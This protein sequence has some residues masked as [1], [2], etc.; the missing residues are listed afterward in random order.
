MSISLEGFFL[1]LKT[2]SVLLDQKNRLAVR[3]VGQFFSVISMQTRWWRKD[4]KGGAGACLFGAA[5]C[6]QRGNIGYHVTSIPAIRSL[7]TGST[8]GS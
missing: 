7:K 6:K 3:V 4:V 8:K 5:E 1:A 2:L